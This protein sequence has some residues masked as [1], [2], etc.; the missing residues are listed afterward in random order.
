MP[1]KKSVIEWDPPIYGS[2]KFMDVLKEKTPITGST[3]RSLM[4][5]DLIEQTR[6]QLDPLLVIETRYMGAVYFLSI[7]L[8]HHK[9]LFDTLASILKAKFDTLT[10]LSPQDPFI[11]ENFRTVLLEILWLSQNQEGI[12]L[13]VSHL[14]RLAK[15]VHPLDINKKNLT[16]TLFQHLFAC[17]QWYSVT[18]DSKY[19]ALIV[20]WQEI[21]AAKFKDL[22]QQLEAVSAETDL[23]LVENLMSDLL[24]VPFLISGINQL[25]SE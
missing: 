10:T 8:S 21:T 13:A 11:N 17:T 14:P 1:E 6:S 22:Q 23:I 24:L 25:L 18:K 19:K 2:K 12:E 16:L 3:I 4:S 7:G 9:S 15:A 20:G 5:S